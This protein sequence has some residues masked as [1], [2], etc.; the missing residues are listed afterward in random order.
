M[1]RA[2]P[3]PKDAVLVELRPENLTF[4]TRKC[5][6]PG[7]SVRFGLVMEE[8][9]LKMTAAVE[10]CL[11]VAKSWRGYGYHCRLSLAEASEGDRHL[12][13]LFIDK[14]RGKAALVRVEPS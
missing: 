7:T 8:K 13:Q 10:A 14:G 1:T 11:V 9:P 6:L 4:E 12:V 5:L 2:V 3:L